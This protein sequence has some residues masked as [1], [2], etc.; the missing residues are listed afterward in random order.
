M[1]YA[2]GFLRVSSAKQ[3]LVGDSPSDQ[4]EQILRRSEQLSS[5]LGTSITIIEWFEFTESASGE[6]DMQPILKALDFCKNPKN[7][8]KYCF[9]KSIDRGTRGGATIYGQLKAQ[10]SRYGVQF[11]DVYGVIGT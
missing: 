9:I 8:I 4:Q 10:F 11:V 1:E 3:G 2:I 7:K 5:L 6:F